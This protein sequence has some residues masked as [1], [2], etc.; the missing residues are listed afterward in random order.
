MNTKVRLSSIDDTAREGNK[1]R[2][3]D[4]ESCNGPQII[5]QLTHL[6]MVDQKPIFS[7]GTVN[8]KT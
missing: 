8:N 2:A 3:G 6:I 5:I 1:H 4:R 7:R